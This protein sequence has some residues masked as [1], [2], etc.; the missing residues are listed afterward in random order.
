[1]GTDWG[2][3]LKSPYF[4][5]IRYPDTENE[6]SLDDKPSLF[7]SLYLRNP[8]PSAVDLFH[9]PHILRR[10]HIGLQVLILFVLGFIMT[11]SCSNLN[12]SPNRNRVNYP[13]SG[14]WQGEGVDSEG[15]DAEIYIGQGDL[16]DE[17]FKGSYKGPVDGTY[18]MWRIR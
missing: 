5:A 13:F 14:N 12:P 1:M 7:S 15:A 4:K 18:T 9:D 10:S 16:E 3:L 17:L 11:T 6:H 2:N 8:R